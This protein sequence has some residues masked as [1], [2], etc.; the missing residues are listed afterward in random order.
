MKD[1]LQQH[2]ISQLCFG[3]GIWTFRLGVDTFFFQSLYIIHM[4]DQMFNKLNF[5]QFGIR[6]WGT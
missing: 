3:K 1:T 5:E 2:G 4:F 6:V